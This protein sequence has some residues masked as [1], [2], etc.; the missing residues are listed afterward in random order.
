MIEIL[1]GVG[2]ETIQ[3]NCRIRGDDTHCSASSR[4]AR[5]AEEKPLFPGSDGARAGVRWMA[6]FLRVSG[7]G[8]RT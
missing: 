6:G 1:A 5:F 4:D 7:Q 8:V 2:G 3:G